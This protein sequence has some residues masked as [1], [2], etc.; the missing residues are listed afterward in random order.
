VNVRYTPRSRRDL[1]AIY[2]YINQQNPVAARSVKRAIQNAVEM[3]AE[4]PHIG[5]VTE[6]SPEFR[7]VRAGRYPY[8]I[9]YR[10]RGDEVW[11]VHIRDIRRKTWAGD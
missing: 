4:F 3:L 9:Y 5:T 2:D 7:G 6:R 10:I 8:R 11:I 1:E